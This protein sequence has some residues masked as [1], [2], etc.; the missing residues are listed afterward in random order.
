M[1]LD[2]RLKY[3]TPIGE[4]RDGI[5]VAFVVRMSIGC[6][7]LTAVIALLGHG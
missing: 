7:G 2:K 5:V 3:E 4:P 6:I 1:S